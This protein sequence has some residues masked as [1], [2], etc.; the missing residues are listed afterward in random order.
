MGIIRDSTNARMVTY[1]CRLPINSQSIVYLVS[2]T[3]IDSMVIIP[4]QAMQSVPTVINGPIVIS[5]ECG[6]NMRNTTRLRMNHY[7]RRVNMEGPSAAI[8]IL[9]VAG[10]IMGGGVTMALLGFISYQWMNNRDD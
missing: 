6:P 3:D 5:Y 7:H 1:S 2:C 4:V 10:S 9:I 8:L